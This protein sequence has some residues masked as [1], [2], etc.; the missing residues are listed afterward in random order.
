MDGKSN[1]TTRDNIL[2]VRENIRLH[3]QIS[4]LERELSA[5][6]ESL[7]R[8]WWECLR[9]SDDYAA[10]LQGAPDEPYA[11]MASD[12]GELHHRFEAWWLE[13][14]RRLFAEQVHHADIAVVEEVSLDDSDKR[15]V[16][17]RDGAR[18]SLYLRIPLTLERREITR[19]FDDILDINYATHAAEIERAKHP[20][21][22]FYPDQ[23][24]RLGTIKT[25]LEIWRARTNTDEEW[26]RMGERL[27]IRD[28]FT[29]QPEDDAATIKRKRRLMTQTVQRYHH[30]AAK[31]IEFAARGD[32]PRV[33]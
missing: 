27:K 3:N 29:C 28:E 14:G 15:L 8:L 9:E 26:W 22:G 13:T 2:K 18:P 7:Y 1:T 19:Q 10:A 25:L 23:R 21:R 24:I 17:W 30:M 5:A 32:F 33:K 31:M 11:S 20:R 4:L 6:K 16:L 12:F